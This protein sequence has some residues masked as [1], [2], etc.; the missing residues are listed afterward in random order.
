MRRAHGRTIR[1]AIAP[2]SNR[3][4]SISDYIQKLK[5]MVPTIRT[6]EKLDQFEVLQRVIEYI[7]I[8]EEAL[9]ITVNP[10]CSTVV[11]CSEA[12]HMQK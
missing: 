6:D 4:S 7:Q 1:E 3:G 10:E 8:L 5:Q 9:G 11:P 12:A 2:A